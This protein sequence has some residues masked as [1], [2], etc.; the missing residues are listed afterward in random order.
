MINQMQRSLNFGEILPSYHPKNIYN[1]STLV[2][3]FHIALNSF[4]L[5]RMKISSCF[6]GT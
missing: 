2:E 4:F 1:D 3:D 5:C 6:F